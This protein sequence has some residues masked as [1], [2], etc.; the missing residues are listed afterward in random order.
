MIRTR[1]GEKFD[2]DTVVEDYQRVYGLKKF[3]NVSPKVEPTASGVI[4]IFEV[5]E[6]KQIK[7]IVFRGNKAIENSALTDTIDVRAGEAVDRFR[8]NLAVQNIQRL[9]KDRNYPFA[10]VEVN[11]DDLAKGDLIFNITE[12]PNVRV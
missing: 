8:I 6:V 5:T 12:G 11:N 2:P 1:E 9:Y 10:R 7:Q 4:V 3:A